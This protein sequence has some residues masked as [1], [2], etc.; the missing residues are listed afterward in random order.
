M[1]F[2]LTKQTKE[3][4]KKALKNREIDPFKMANMTSIE[5]RT[6]LEAYVGKENAPKVNALYE[7]KILLKNQK[8]GYI[9]WAKKIT[10]ITPAVKRDILTKIE[11]LQEVL[12]PKAE[13][14][15]LQDFVNARLNLEVTQIEAKTIAD[16]SKRI[17]EL[18]GKADTD[19]IFPNEAQRLEYG[20]SKVAI[21]KYINDLKLEAKKISF[22]E[23]PIEKIK[24]IATELPGTMKSAVA[25]LDNSLWG[26]QG[27]KTLLDVRTSSIWAKNFLKSWGDLT[28]QTFAKGKWYTSGDDIVLDVIKAD[29][30]SRP[31]AINGKYKAG[32]YGLDVLSEEA[33][34]SSLPEKIP[35]LGRLFKASEAAYNGGA[36][37]LRAD[38]ADRFIKIGEQNG[39]N[40]ASKQDA[41]GM[42]A[43]V[44]SLTGRGSLGKADVLARETNIFLFSVKFF[45]SNLD[46]VTAGLTNKKIRSNPVAR[47]EAAKSLISMIASL[48]IILATAKI[49][50]KDAVDEDPRSTNFGKIKIFGKW[51]DVTG[52]MAGLVRLA[53]YLVP[54]SHDG[55]I[56]LWKK[57]SSGTYVDL[58]EGK[59]GQQN[60][61]DLLLD[62]L[63]SNKLSPIAGLFRDAW[64]G[65]FFGGQP[66]T[67]GGAIKNIITPISIQTFQDLKNDPS[68]TFVLGSMIF[69]ALGFSVN[70]YP[71]PNKTTNLIPIGEESEQDSFISSA[72]IYANAMGTD[73]ET[74]FNRIFTGQKILQVRN[75]AIIVERM[76]VG[77][78]QA[79]KKKYG[80]DTKQVKLDH[81]VPLELGGGN[82]PDN[83][84]LVSTSEW[85]SYTAVENALGRA[86]KKKKVSKD[87]AHRLIKKFKS[88][89]DTKERKAYGEEIKAKYK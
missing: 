2:C 51:T 56:S 85:S 58:L 24:E 38:L 89:E 67:V 45:K 57:S 21:E 59:Y 82:T 17:V 46:T 81:T 34:P 44:S 87:E 6:F 88:I 19:G 36:L 72:I 61:F 54:S 76:D 71:E 64:K 5:R 10:G 70:S 41:E 23:Q 32:G 37:R 3:N 22:R 7:S 18:E 26:R 14:A 62:G 55:K 69:E 83:L 16:L 30:Y 40:M 4:F 43:L 39:L 74:A 28:K 48:A 8:A 73:P 11:R 31:N 42:G 20:A 78:S 86:L 27:I 35:I 68:A 63:I 50:D 49:I 79:Y 47:K 33:Y 13:E 66:F 77:D 53:S 9:T 75:G 80:K 15:F 52:G 29:I 60:A 84:K 65:K 12:D 1:A 25:S